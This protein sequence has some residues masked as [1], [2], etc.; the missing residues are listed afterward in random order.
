[1]CVGGAL[2]PAAADETQSVLSEKTATDIAVNLAHQASHSQGFSITSIHFEPSTREWAIAVDAS[3]DIN[4]TEHFTAA[5]N[6][7]TGLA[8]LRLPPAMGCVV[9]ANIQQKVADAQAKAEAEAVARKY[10][11]PDL[12]Q[13]AEALIRYQYGAEQAAENGAAG[14]RYFVTLPS[15]DAKGTVDLAAD[16]IASLKRDG[17]ETQPG[18][19]WKRGAFN[20][21]RDM[22]FTIGL[23]VRRS[24]GNY[25]VS[26]SSFCGMLCAAWYT[27]VMRHDQA[28]W[29]VVST[30]KT[31]VS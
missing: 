6:E 5:L 18:S 19:S 7:S 27:A 11:A 30:V 9:Q 2:V 28:G 29:H 14:S 13:L 10:P 31:A 15:P 26:Y 4:T 8:C 1:M 20:A 25:D 12:Q 24:D 3:I 21:G 17:I 16:E 23:P 22:L